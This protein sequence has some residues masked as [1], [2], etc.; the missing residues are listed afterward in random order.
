MVKTTMGVV[1]NGSL[2]RMARTTSLIG[3]RSRVAADGDRFELRTHGVAAQRVER[4]GSPIDDLAS[5][6]H[7]ERSSAITSRQ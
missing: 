5:A 7:P 3:A 2:A 6:R 4:R 1:R